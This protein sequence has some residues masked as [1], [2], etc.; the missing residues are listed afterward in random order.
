MTEPL[1]IRPERP[2]DYA[3]VLRLTYEAFQT[4]DY[5]GRRRIDE[6]FLYSLLQ[7][8]PFVIPGLCFVAERGGELVGHILYTRS[9]VRRPDGTET[10]TITF[11]PLSVL[12]KYHRQG[13]GRALVRHSMEKAREMGFGAVLIVG[14]PDYYP[15]LGF[16]RGRAFG[17]T[18][19]DGSADDPFMAYELVPGFLRGGGIFDWLVPEFGIA[20]N[21]DEGY[22]AFHRQFMASRFP[23]QLTLRP[24]FDGDTALMERWLYADHVK[25]WYE[26][27]GDW[28][29]EIADRRAEFRFITH[30]IAEFEGVPEGFCQYYDCYAARELEDWGMEIPAPG[31][32]FSMDYLIGGAAYLRRGFGR[33]M[34]AQ[35]LDRLRALGAKRVIVRP[36][37]ANAASRQ[38]LEGCG[39]AWDGRAGM[40]GL[41]YGQ[42]AENQ[43][44][45]GWKKRR[46]KYHDHLPRHS[47][48][49]PAGPA[50]AFSLGGVVERAL[51][52]KTGRRHAKLRDSL[53]RLGRRAPGRPHQRHGR[54]RY[55]RLRAL[56]AGAPGI[57]APGHRQAPGGDGARALPGVSAH[58]RGG[59]Q[60]RVGVLRVLWLQEGRGRQPDVYHEPVDVGGMVAWK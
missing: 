40:G 3:A 17:L 23:G 36:E 37:E 38:L 44:R 16:R 32:V 49:H 45:Y 56:S 53:F 58:R 25:P 60:R 13:I 33:A 21:D 11:G 8:C 50:G 41:S 7:G 19:P 55:D 47:R 31:E 35:M 57:P 27:P 22:A 4:L 15:K 34:V 51:S 54:R 52:R 48:F 6:H 14:V 39:F 43:K 10:E 20:E 5:P 12:P 42:S 1:T 26:H 46:R 29:R 9:L 18:L 24:F 28:L 30:L 59:V 2:A